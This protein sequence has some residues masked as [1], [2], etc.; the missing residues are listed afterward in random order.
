[1]YI[2]PVNAYGYQS[3]MPRTQGS[4]TEPQNL[5]TPQKED[6]TKKVLLWSGLA[7]ALATVAAFLLKGKGIKNLFKKSVHTEVP[8]KPAKATE[9]PLKDTNLPKVSKLT[10]QETERNIENAGKTIKDAVTGLSYKYDQNGF[11][12]NVLDANGKRIRII[13]RKSDGSVVSYLDCIRDANGKET[14]V[15][16]READG[17]VIRYGDY[18]YDA[19]GI[20]KDVIGYNSDGTVIK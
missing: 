4:V 20:Q 19:N 6:K 14:K 18:I 8:P 13:E 12:K 7:I 15:I 5:L 17:S 1:M 11:V 10:L 9:I 16:S 3:Y 2:S